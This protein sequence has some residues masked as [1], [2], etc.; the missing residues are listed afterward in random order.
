MSSFAR[1]QTRQT[2][3]RPANAGPAEIMNTSLTALLAKVDQLP[4]VDDSLEVEWDGPSTDAAIAAVE[5]ALNIEIRGSYRDFVL[6]RG[7]GGLDALR[8]SS[9]EADDPL[10][11]ACADSLYYREAWCTHALPAHLLVIQRDD[12]DNEPVCLD[13]SRVERG[14]N[15]VVLFYPSSG[16]LELLAPGFADYYASFLEPYFDDAGL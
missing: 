14:E 16:H 12:D 15:P 8:I 4:A 1:V 2:R 10:S 5:K 6:L 3:P 9:I 7:G 11:G 13:T